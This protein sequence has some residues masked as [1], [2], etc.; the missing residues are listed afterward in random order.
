[1]P[2]KLKKLLHIDRCCLLLDLRLTPPN[3]NPNNISEL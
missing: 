1:V 3:L 2:S